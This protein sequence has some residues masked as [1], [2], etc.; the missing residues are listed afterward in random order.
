[1]PAQRPAPQPHIGLFGLRAKIALP[2]S[3]LALIIGAAAAYLMTQVLMT[4]LEHRFTTQVVEGGRRVADTVARVEREHLEQWRTM[5]YTEGLVEALQSKDQAELTQILGL[6]A[7]NACMDAVDV[8]DLSGQIVFSARRQ[9]LQDCTAYSFAVDDDAPVEWP[10][11]R[12]ALGGIRDDLGDKYAELVNHSGRWWLATSGPILSEDGA[13]VGVLVIRRALETLVQQARAAAMADVSFLQPGAGVLAT[14]F[15]AQDDT[16]ELLKEMEPA[17]SA[18]PP[19]GGVVA[20]LRVAT[21]SFVHVLSPL[22]LRGANTGSFFSAALPSRW[23]QQAAVPLRNELAIAIGLAVMLTL[24][25]G[26]GL[27]SR[28]AGPVQRLVHASRRVAQGDLTQQVGARE[29]D[30]IGELARSFNVMVEGLRERERERDI[31]GRV[32]SPLVREKF[33]S[34]ELELGGERRRV[35]VL[36]ADIRGFTHR[37]ESQ[38]PES[39]VSMLN[40]YFTSMTAAVRVWGGTVNNFIGD[41]LLVVFGA[42]ADIADEEWMAVRAALNMRAALAELNHT[43]QQRGEDVIEAGI[44]ICTGEVVA[45][46]IGSPERLMYTVIGDTVNVAARLETL[47]TSFPGH[48]ILIDSDTAHALR[49]RADIVLTPLGPQQLRGRSQAVEVFSVHGADDAT[50]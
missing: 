30:E 17:G 42:P 23:M 32:V 9:N 37:T 21:E 22:Q 33:L 45:G 7:L 44:G 16:T 39:V 8:M 28:I 3:L 47:T 13:V 38:P 19:S 11:A 48:P 34:G 24:L 2:Y 41:A 46:Q 10:G 5:A 31:F 6:P 26:Q 36:F 50:V 27:A 35:T 43:R 1:M 49:D 18:H 12:R 20:P 15:P 40:E 25:L 14:S 29:R 4:R